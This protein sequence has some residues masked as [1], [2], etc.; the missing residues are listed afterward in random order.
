MAL[1]QLK[2]VTVEPVLFLYMF[3]TLL[4]YVAVQDMVYKRVC[5]AEYAHDVCDGL[6][7]DAHHAERDFVQVSRGL[8]KNIYSRLGVFNVHISFMLM[9]C[10]KMRVLTFLGL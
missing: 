9:L 7:G 1:V 5:L 2:Y 6:E 4:Q 8:E 3:A 10:D